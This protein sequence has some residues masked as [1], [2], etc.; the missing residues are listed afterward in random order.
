M[1]IGIDITSSESVQD[2]VGSLADEF[3]GLAVL[4][5]AAGG[6]RP[7]PEFTDTDD[8]TWRALIDLNLIGVVRCVRAALPHLLAAS[9]GGSSVVTIG[10]VNGLTSLGSEPYSA[11]KAGLQN[12][13]SNLAVQY[14]PRGVRFNLIAP[15]SVRTRVWDSQPGALARLTPLYPLGRIGEPDDIAAAV[16]FLASDDAA[17]ITGATIPVD[18]GILA[19]GGL[20]G[21]S[22]H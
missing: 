21:A 8:E 16:A 9:T 7:H 17:W 13:T 22:T 18:G 15:G 19:S 12:L 11:A 4:V 20:R 14:G 6:D 1:A 3:G 2:A 10:S 5:N